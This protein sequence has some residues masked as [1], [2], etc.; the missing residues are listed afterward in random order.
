VPKRGE[1]LDLLLLV[2]RNAK[3]AFESRF[4]IPKSEKTK[5]LETLQQELGLA[6][7]PKRIEAFD[8]S[9]IQGTETVASAVVCEGGLMSRKQYRRFRIKSV[10]GP[11]DYASIYEVVYRRYRRQLSEGKPL[12][13]L[14]LIDGGKGQLHFAYQALA[15]LGIDDT[16]LASIAKRE[17]LI[18]VQGQEEAIVLGPQSSML[19]LL[20]EIRDEAHRFAVTYHRKRRSARD[21]ASE[22]DSIPGIGEKRKRRLLQNF[23]SVAGVRRATI[24]ELSPFVGSKLA[25]RIKKIFRQ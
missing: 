22:L 9:N 1:K 3:I 25:E 17:E 10:E 8:V 12:P 18:F 20:Q 15:K 4:K 14:I 5:V 6:K 16:P 23:G 2:E 19:H 21:F 24:E 13:D 11:D 7:L